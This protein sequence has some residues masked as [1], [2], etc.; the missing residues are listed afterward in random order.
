MK[1]EKCIIVGASGS[2]KDYLLRGL[3]KKGLRYS[4]K[5][6]TRPQ[7][8]LETN[9][10]EYFFI[11]NGDFESMLESNQVLTYQKFDIFGSVWHYAI[12]K[13]NF[14]DNQVFI[15]TPHELSTID[16]EI[17]K[18]CFVVYLDI[19][20]DIRRGRITGRNENVDSV[21]RRLNADEEDFK[22]FKDYDLKIS[23]PDFD[24]DM[25]YDLMN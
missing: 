6:T 8:K 25:V 9:G 17:R 13:D 4:P 18:G 11:Q 5:Y 14:Q 12:S 20:M 23:D 15:M 19:D 2:G 24:V 1:N 3:V 10:L 21:D 22:D 7:R 16:S